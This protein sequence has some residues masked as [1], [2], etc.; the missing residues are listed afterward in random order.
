[1]DSQRIKKLDL[2]RFKKNPILLESHDYWHRNFLKALNTGLP[3]PLG[4]TIKTIEIEGKVIMIIQA[5]KGK[6]TRLKQLTRGRNTDRFMFI[7][8]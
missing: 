5:S 2:K 7:V 6:K 4:K 3:E 1:M 8:I